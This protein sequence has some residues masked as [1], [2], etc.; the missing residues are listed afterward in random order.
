MLYL[1]INIPFYKELLKKIPKLNKLLELT[2]LLRFL[3]QSV[4]FI[5]LWLAAGESLDFVVNGSVGQ[6]SIGLKG[7][8][9][10]KSR[11]N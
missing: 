10:S 5:H 7:P 9:I 1:S 6:W 3:Q 8:Q 2:H 4:I 11:I